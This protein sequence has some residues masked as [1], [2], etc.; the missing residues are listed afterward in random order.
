MSTKK[1][2]KKKTKPTDRCLLEQINSKKYFSFKELY[3]DISRKYKT[4]YKA[5]NGRFNK[6]EKLGHIVKTDYNLSKEFS[7]S[8]A[9]L[10]FLNPVGGPRRDIIINR[11]HNLLF[12]CKITHRPEYAFK[13]GFHVNADVKNWSNPQY[14]K[15]LKNGTHIQTS[16]NHITVRVRE[17]NC[18]D[19]DI[20]VMQ[21]FSEV[22][23]VLSDL[24]IKYKPL[25]LAYPDSVV[26][27]IQQHHA[28]KNKVISELVQEFDIKYKDSR[29]QVDNSKGTPEIEFIHP[30]KAQGDF[31]QV[32]GFLRIIAEGKL[33]IERLVE[34][35]GRI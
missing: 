14:Y 30:K 4:S 24:M 21:A 2:Q 34:D 6:L 28:I 23:E 25:K 12:K 29:I 16:D 15:T 1:I 20:A 31:M 19:S 11:A 35:Y 32:V 9:G 13:V 27:L 3:Q 5:L 7:V 17:I 8:N 33:D 22:C 10:L 18:Y 26:N